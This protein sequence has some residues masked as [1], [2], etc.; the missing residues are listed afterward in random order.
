MVSGLHAFMTLRHSLCVIKFILGYA[1]SSVGL[2]TQFVTTP[3]ICTFREE[4]A[5]L[6]SFQSFYFVSKSLK[7]IHA[8]EIVWG[9]LCCEMHL[10]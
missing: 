6:K 3:S 2:D 10:T 9:L 4:I 8:N 5:L 7:H 1:Y